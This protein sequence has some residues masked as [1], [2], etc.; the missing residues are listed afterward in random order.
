MRHKSSIRRIDTRRCRAKIKAT[1]RNRP[2]IVHCGGPEH[3]RNG[4]ERRHGGNL[5]DLWRLAHRHLPGAAE[6]YAQASALYNHGQSAD[7]HNDSGPRKPGLRPQDPNPD[8]SAA[9]VT[10]ENTHSTSQHSP[11]YAPFSLVYTEFQHILALSSRNLAET[12]TAVNKALES[13][14]EQDDQAAGELANIL[15]DRDTDKTE[16]PTR[17]APPDNYTSDDNRAGEGS[18]QARTRLL[19][20]SRSQL[21]DSQLA[22]ATL[23]GGQGPQRTRS[24]ASRLDG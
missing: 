13:F 15:E 22:A 6:Y 16:N 19:R 9:F 14:K 21:R 2:S 8:M 3:V 1:K 5:Y 12:A 23:V 7:R 10:G 4:N 11:I 20:R 17:P 24:Y 18:R